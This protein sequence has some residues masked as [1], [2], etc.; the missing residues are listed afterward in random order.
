MKK[1][2]F[3]WD[4]LIMFEYFRSI[5]D[6]SGISHK[7]L[8]QKLLIL[9]LLLGGKC[10]NSVIHHC[11]TS[12]QIRSFFWS[13]FSPNAGKYGP[14]KTPYLDTFH[15][16]HFTI[17]KMILSKTSI[18]F[19]PEH[20]LRHSKPGKKLDFFQYRAYSDPKLCILECLKEYIRRRNDKADQNQWR[21]FTTHM[22]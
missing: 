5:E 3:V 22:K 17:S 11:V 7:H 21:L 2:I 16:V 9:L 10:L 20:V 13:V 14:E 12:V 1:F 15:V 19:S 6:N 4:V 18:S 8:L